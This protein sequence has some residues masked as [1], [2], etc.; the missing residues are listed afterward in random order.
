[1]SSLVINFV[2]SELVD[3]FMFVLGMTKNK[4]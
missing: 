3:L 4:G 2:V 1:V